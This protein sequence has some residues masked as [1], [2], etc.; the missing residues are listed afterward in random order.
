MN[1]YH[2]WCDLREGVD[3]LEFAD[4]VQAYL[5]SLEEDGVLEG[6][7]L[8]RR[9]LGLGHP[10]LGEFHVQ[11]EFVDLKQ[12]DDAFGSV[13]RRTD[14]IESFHFAVNSKVRNFVA[15]LYRDFP[16]EVRESGEERRSRR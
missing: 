9:K 2:I 14:P 16:D 11:L 1:I 5:G 12:L 15:A 13:A 4:A 8:T 3:D 6:F 10:A 7:R